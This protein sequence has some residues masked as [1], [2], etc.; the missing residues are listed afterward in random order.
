MAKG[1]NYFSFIANEIL[2]FCY[3][4]AVYDFFIVQKLCIKI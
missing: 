3:F 1:I 4:T 2:C